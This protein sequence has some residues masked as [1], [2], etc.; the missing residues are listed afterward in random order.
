MLFRNANSLARASTPA[1]RVIDDGQLVPEEALGAVS[2]ERL[3]RFPS[4]G[5]R[6]VAAMPPTGAER[7]P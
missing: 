5:D 4:P 1:G 2:D 7:S 6:A 3:P